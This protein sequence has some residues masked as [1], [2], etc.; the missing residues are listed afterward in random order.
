[1]GG[2]VDKITDDVLGFDPGG[3]GLLGDVGATVYDAVNDTVGLVE[4]V[5]VDSPIG[6][7]IAFAYPPAAPYIYAAKA[8]DAA[9]EGD[10]L[11]TAA[12]AFGA[13]LTYPTVNGTEAVS[14]GIPVEDYST[15]LDGTVSSLSTS[16]V[17]SHLSGSDVANNLLAFDDNLGE[18]VEMA[19]M[20]SN[21]EGTTSFFDQTTGT[22]FIAPFQEL[23]SV[24][25]TGA[26]L[27]TMSELV[28]DDD[29]GAVVN[30]SELPENWDLGT[31]ENVN[32]TTDGGITTLPNGIEITD[33]TTQLSPEDME[34]FG[35]TPDF[36]DDP[37]GWASARYSTDNGLNFSQMIGDALLAGQGIATAGGII[38]TLSGGSRGYTSEGGITNIAPKTVTRGAPR[39]VPNP[40]TLPTIR[41]GY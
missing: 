35:Y 3:G 11:S 39:E 37:V 36:F 28:Y 18:F 38:D 40:Y 19:D 41:A 10:W 22:E 32:I 1:M 24:I 31:G 8:A 30:K 17:A 16:D 4:D 33:L 12:N 14:T 27:E 20:P 15:Q 26:P 21:W 6:N 25:E 7:V 23:Q 13:Y 34:K 29:L 2:I 9:S 5:V